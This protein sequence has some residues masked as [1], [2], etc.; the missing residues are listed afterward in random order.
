M[1]GDRY[2]D[3]R[4]HVQ[5]AANQLSRPLRS[6]ATA[7][8]D[9]PMLSSCSNAAARG[10]TSVKSPDLSG[11]ECQ[12]AFMEGTTFGIATPAAT[13]P[14]RRARTRTV[15]QPAAVRA[16]TTASQPG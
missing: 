8:C 11:V 10:F 3:G 6:V 7:V 15:A 14:R 12:A 13:G 16:M 1:G 4:P 5:T 2:D 9:E